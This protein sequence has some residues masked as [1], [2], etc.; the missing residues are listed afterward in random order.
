[1]FVPSSTALTWVGNFDAW[2]FDTV[3]LDDAVMQISAYLRNNYNLIVTDYDDTLSGDLGAGTV[4]L[5]L[6]TQMD[7]GDA[8]ADDGVT[9]IR[10]NV[11][12]AWSHVN[13]YGSTP[14]NLS[15]STCSITSLIP[16]AGGGGPTYSFSFRNLLPTWLGGAPVTPEQ[17]AAYTAEG[18]AAISAVGANAATAYGPGSASAQTATA[19]ATANS[20][21]FGVDEA[22]LA[23]KQNADAAASDKWVLFG[24]IA[25]VAVVGVVVAL[26]YLGAARSVTR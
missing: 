20:A 18:Q 3:S 23:A 22:K 19:A 13:T 17:Q 24:L 21:A 2:S 1:M 11:D 4:T 12:D 8:G 15:G 14:P 7:R 16:S 26:P 10:S 25:A 6:Q 5:R 9:D